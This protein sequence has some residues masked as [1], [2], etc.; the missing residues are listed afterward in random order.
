MP[1]QQDIEYNLAPQTA[2]VYFVSSHHR[3]TRGNNNKSIWTISND[4]EVE[5]FIFS[6]NSNWVDGSICW[7]LR[8]LNNVI[9]VIG[10]NP[11][12]EDLKIAKF[13]DGTNNNIW[14]GYPADCKNK[15]QD[16]PNTEVL[17]IWKN[18]NYLSKSDVRKLKQQ[19]PCNL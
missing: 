4:E 3:R 18:N 1:Y 15:K 7:G 2:S 8:L 16:I 5:C 6:K 13:V 12:R 11:A 10:R 9:Q 14:H 19:L 17:T